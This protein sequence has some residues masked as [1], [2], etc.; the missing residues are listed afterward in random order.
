[1]KK[2]TR[3]VGL[4]VHKDT[5]AVAIADVGG[6]VEFK[7]QIANHEASIRRLLKQLTSGVGR[8][9]IKIVYEAGPCGFAL[10]RL[11]V[12]MHF[13]CEV[14][15]PS[16]VA[17]RAGDRVKTDRRDAIKLAREARAGEL[18]AVRVPTAVEEAFRDLVRAREAAVKELRRARHRL[19]KFL[20]RHDVREPEKNKTW[21]TRYMAW[22]GALSFDD[23]MLQNVLDDGRVEIAHQQERVTRFEREI[24]A[25][26]KHL[27]TVAQKTITA[28]QALRGVKT[29]TA[30]T[31][32]AEVGSFTRFESASQLMSY[33]G[34]VPSEYSSGSKQRRG[35]ITK[36]GNA[37]LRRIIGELVWSYTRGTR[38]GIELR[39]RRSLADREVVAIAERAET[40]LH[41]RFYSLVL[42]GK[43]RNVAA[44]AIARE[45]LG[46]I[47]AIG[48][49][50]EQK[51]RKQSKAAG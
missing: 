49:N 17:Q 34:D 31:I 12:S 50:V 30:A 47:W 27:E 4:D 41:D 33:A 39:R 26:I 37:H 3:F 36:T 9:A 19:Q 42:K 13:A 32:V 20:L 6:E 11:L 46:F 14:I 15:A 35:A 38:A 7:G 45:A 10:F 1:M 2:F 28:L 25:S 5:I 24:E 8:A 48:I 40:R 16:L 44:T 22:L 21:S 51:E 23:P 18:T 29:L 43:V